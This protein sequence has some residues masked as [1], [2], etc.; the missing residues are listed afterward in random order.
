MTQ[1]LNN[2]GM[3]IIAKGSLV[4]NEQ[5]IA[6]E[7]F[8]SNG[9]IIIN[10]SFILGSSTTEIKNTYSF[11]KEETK[12]TSEED[13]Y[14]LDRSTTSSIFPIC[15]VCDKSGNLRL[16][17]DSEAYKNIKLILTSKNELIISIN[18][19]KF[20]I[21]TSLPTKK[22]EAKKSLNYLIEKHQSN[23]K[24]SDGF[25]KK[26]LDTKIP[27]GKLL[28]LNATFEM[29]VKN[30]KSEQNKKNSTQNFKQNKDKISSQTK[31]QQ[32]QLTI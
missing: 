10:V 23:K 7:I 4:Y 27:F 9:Q 12:S 13:K 16:E 30:V 28:I 21:K 8:K 29:F 2:D 25:N 31:T 15:I 3:Y 17:V 1:V 18:E 11:K 6:Y 32:L 19:Q 26:S 22:T 5:P 24:L 20:L 14:V